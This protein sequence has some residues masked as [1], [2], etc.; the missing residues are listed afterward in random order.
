MFSIFIVTLLILL[1]IFKSVEAKKAKKLAKGIWI[2]SS[3]NAEK[4]SYLT[5]DVDTGKYQMSIAGVW[6]AFGASETVTCRNGIL[7]VIRN[8]KQEGQIALYPEMLYSDLYLAGKDSDFFPYFSSNVYPLQIQFSHDG[9]SM[10]MTSGVVS[11]IITSEWRK[12]N[13]IPVIDQCKTATFSKTILQ[14]QRQDDPRCELY[15]G[16]CNENSVDYVFDGPNGLT[17]T[18]T[19]WDDNGGTPYTYIIKNNITQINYRAMYP[20][21]PTGF[22]YP[23]TYD[24]NEIWFTDKYRRSMKT[25]SGKSFSVMGESAVALDENTMFIATGSLI[26]CYNIAT[27]TRKYSSDPDEGFFG[28][29]SDAPSSIT[30]DKS[31]SHV[32]LLT[33]NCV[34]VQCLSDDKNQDGGCSSRCS[35]WPYGYRMDFYS[36]ATLKYVKSVDIPQSVNGRNYQFLRPVFNHGNNLAL[37]VNQYDSGQSLY[38]EVTF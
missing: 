35:Y 6:S 15:P 8:D 4:R 10:N 38:T 31:R 25:P 24:G 30:I 19:S 9:L 20:S 12:V 18:G 13:S 1:L 37:G 36:V 27:N 11:N 3:E 22:D 32:V 21:L 14:L 7:Q 16:L 23:F 34:D 29:M 17:V 28:S 5:L 33:H 2:M 26:E